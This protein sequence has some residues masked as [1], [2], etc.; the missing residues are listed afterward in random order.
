MCKLVRCIRRWCADLAVWQEGH[1]VAVAGCSP[2][3]EKFIRDLSVVSGNMEKGILYLSALDA[4]A[5]L[6]RADDLAL[7]T[8]TTLPPMNIT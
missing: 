3:G 7:T 2:E 8:D 6:S 4:D 5:A 1:K